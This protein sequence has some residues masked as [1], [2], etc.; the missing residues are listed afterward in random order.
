M[1]TETRSSNNEMVCVPREL[2][3]RCDFGKNATK[4]LAALPELRAILAQPV[5]HQ[6]EQTPAAMPIPEDY[7][8][9]PRRLTAENGAKALLLGEFK[10]NVARECPVCRDLEEPLEGC[11]VCDGEGEFA[12]SHTIP[13]DQIKFIY[14]VA[15]KGLALKSQTAGGA[16]QMTFEYVHADGER[17]TVSVSREEVAEHMDG[18]L[19]EKLTE[20]ICHC[21]PIGETNIVDCRCDE[22][23]DQFELVKP[24]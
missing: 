18:E 17:R 5:Q 1:P 11:D 19:F 15:V 22:V 13:W 9:M 10:L 14:S 16:S 24:S 6:G 8:L 3:E 23:A 2:L 20:T 12:Q 21:E 7:C 4:A